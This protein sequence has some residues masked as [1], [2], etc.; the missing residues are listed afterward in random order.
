MNQSCSAWWRCYSPI[1]TESLQNHAHYSHQ[2]ESLTS[3]LPTLSCQF[4]VYLHL[5]ME[6]W[7]TRVLILCGEAMKFNH[8]LS[9][10]RRWQ[11]PS[12]SGVKSMSYDVSQLR[13]FTRMSLRR[14][15][16][17]QNKDYLCVRLSHF[18]DLIILKENRPEY[19]QIDKLKYYPICCRGEQN[20]F[21]YFL[22]RK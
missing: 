15:I 20:L 18:W 5:P 12:P 2:I 3:I 11:A 19:W 22:F 14:N 10:R 6:V 7:W 9:W 21:I 8:L 13:N 17:K 16:S 4:Y 1:N